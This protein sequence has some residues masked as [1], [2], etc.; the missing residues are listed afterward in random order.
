MTESLQ[1]PA[2]TAAESPVYFLGLPTVIKATGATTGGVLGLVEHL[3]I[4][5]GFASPLHTHHREDESF[6]VLEGAIAVLCGDTWTRADA[7]AFVFGPRGTPHGFAVLGD[8][9]ARLL[10]LCAPA[11]FEGFIAELSTAA[12]E[13][14]DLPRLVQVAEAYEIDIHGPLPPIPDSIA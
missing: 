4:P 10:L 14:P 5:P 9:P 1:S 11:G 12:P 2:R 3:T 6:Y 7:G 8:S 13:P